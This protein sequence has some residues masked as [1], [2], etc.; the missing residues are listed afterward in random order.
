MAVLVREPGAD[1]SM[2]PLI[3]GGATGQIDDRGK[4]V[5]ARQALGQAS[6]ADL[7]LELHLPPKGP[8]LGDDAPQWLRERGLRPPSPHHPC[9]P[10]PPPSSEPPSLAP[11]PVPLVD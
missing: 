3:A 1:G 4:R 10:P 7:R 8:R 9:V 6:K 11:V 2:P 5:N